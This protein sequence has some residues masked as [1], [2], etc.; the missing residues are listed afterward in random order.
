MTSDRNPSEAARIPVHIVDDDE[1]FRTSL[2]RLLTASGYTTYTY[3]SAGDFVLTHDHS[4]AG[5]LLL[6]LHMPGADGLTLQ[7]TL[8]RRNWAI[9]IVFL[10]GRGDVQGSV[11]AMKSGA[12]DFLT[13]PVDLEVLLQAICSAMATNAQSRERSDHDREAR[14]RYD[15]LSDRERTLLRLVLAGTLT[16]DI[17]AQ[18]GVSERT[19]KTCRA[20]VMKKFNAQ[21]LAELALKTPATGA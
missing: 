18:L 3:G 10:S 17:A 14:E 8:K 13:K 5:C 9:P 12:H 19:V 6:D 7:E 11:K 1:S 20:G 2:A 21:N 16:R 15:S 4:P